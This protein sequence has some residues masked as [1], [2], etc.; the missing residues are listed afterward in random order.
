MD[1]LQEDDRNRESVPMATKKLVVTTRAQP[2]LQ[3]CSDGPVNQGFEWYV[4]TMRMDDDGP[5]LMGTER[6]V[7]WK[8]RAAFRQKSNLVF[9]VE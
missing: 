1:R 8:K 5:S 6:M 3:D 7:S 2:L 4:Q 9:V